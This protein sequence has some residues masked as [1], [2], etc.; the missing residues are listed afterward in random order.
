MS[1]NKSKINS[2]LKSVRDIEKSTDIMAE[3]V[4][5]PSFKADIVRSVFEK[6]NASGDIFVLRTI[7][8][9]LINDLL[10]LLD[11]IELLQGSS[12]DHNLNSIILEL[13]EILQ[14][15]DIIEIEAI[16]FN[17]KYHK[18][19]ELIEFPMDMIGEEV[20]IQEVIRKGYICGN[21]ILRPANVAVIAS[22][23]QVEGGLK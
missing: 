6:M 5:D 15:N 19:V 14:R 16:T 21:R 7:F 17:P 10:L 20:V 18:V 3:L 13:N 11:R 2:I 8:N 1:R 9:I 23:K 22:R 12:K 4:T